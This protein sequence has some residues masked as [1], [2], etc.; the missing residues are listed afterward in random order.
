MP[1]CNECNAPMK[2]H[3]MFFDESYSEEYYRK[4]TVVNYTDTSDLLIV[5]GTALET[6]MARRIVAKFLM[7]ELPVIEINL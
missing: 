1:R 7:K 5:T 2:P 3:C 6:N 4:D